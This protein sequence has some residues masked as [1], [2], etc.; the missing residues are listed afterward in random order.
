MDRRMPFRCLGRHEAGE[1]SRFD[2]GLWMFAGTLVLIGLRMPVGV[3]M[4]LVG[5]VG[6]AAINGVDPLLNTLKTLTF[7]QFANYTLTVIPL[8]LLMGEFATKAGMSAALFRAGRAWFGHWR[9]GVAVAT[10]RRRAP[11]RPAPGASVATPPA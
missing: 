1:V 4:L 6:Y 8:F 5:G 10:T 11:S 2:I 3:A 7:S 9:G